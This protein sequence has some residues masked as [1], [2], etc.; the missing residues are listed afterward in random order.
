[1]ERL[2]SNTLLRV[3]V[4]LSVYNYIHRVDCCDVMFGSSC[5]TFTCIVI[6]HPVDDYKSWTEV[7]QM[8]NNNGGNL[9]SF[10]TQDELESVKV[11]AEKLTT[12]CTN[13][14]FIGLK[15]D[16]D[17][18]RTSAASW[19]WSSGESGTPIGTVLNWADGGE[20]NIGDAQNAGVYVTFDGESSKIFDLKKEEKESAVLGYIC[21]KSDPTTLGMTTDVIETPTPLDLLT[22]DGENSYQDVEIV[23]VTDE[24]DVVESDEYTSIDEFTSSPEDE[25]ETSADFTWLQTE[26]EVGSRST[27]ETTMTS[28]TSENPNYFSVENTDSVSA[29]TTTD[30]HTTSSITTTTTTTVTTTKNNND[31]EVH[32][33]DLNSQEQTLVVEFSNNDDQTTSIEISSDVSVG[34]IIAFSGVSGQSI[35]TTL[36][37]PESTQL[38]SILRIK[39][40]ITTNY[41]DIV[42]YSV[43][44]KTEEES[45]SV[46]NII[47]GGNAT[48]YSGIYSYTVYDGV[49]YSSVSTNVTHT[50]KHSGEYLLNLELNETEDAQ[51]IC[52]FWDDIHRSFSTYGCA[53]HND[54]ENNVTSCLFINLCSLFLGLSRHTDVPLT[55]TLKIMELW[56]CLRN[57][58][59]KN[60]VACMVVF[61]ALF[62]F[63][64]DKTE[65]EDSC[66]VIAILL[67]YF[68]LCMFTWMAAEAV[69]ILDK[70]VRK[71]TSKWNRLKYYLIVCYSI[72]AIIVAVT[73]SFSPDNYA[74]DGIC[75]LDV[76]SG[77]IFAFLVPMYIILIFNVMVTLKAVKVIYE[78]SKGRVA[79]HP[80]ESTSMSKPVKQSTATKTVKEAHKVENQQMKRTLRGMLVLIPIFGL[81]WLFAIFAFDSEHVL[82]QYL[83]AI[84]NSF[85]GVYIFIIYCLQDKKIIEAWNRKLGR[86]KRLND[87]NSVEKTNSTNM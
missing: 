45:G 86:R 66:R 44:S 72:P 23:T 85:Q 6:G 37:I 21:E 69:Y 9:V 58:I 1:M 78:R 7:E 84:S 39:T 22:T 34:S 27:A 76:S 80:L 33:Q 71:T 48:L 28:E 3:I 81:T 40:N 55:M 26:S 54:A 13:N 87:M 35:S 67:H 18:P 20:P 60:L 62:V 41:S 53:T 46:V 61:N 68:L 2:Y 50:F 49:G 70:V 65:H 59:H 10:N 24:V 30:R 47:E 32:I 8:C 4:M 12:P 74:T 14:F 77:A 56:N 16:A 57:N 83:F 17:L 73:I 36:I 51:L 5:Y 63:G 75:W 43:Y 82:F 64:A 79:S 25:F 11:E 52:T 42:I 38:T 15:R 19:K 31:L 29:I